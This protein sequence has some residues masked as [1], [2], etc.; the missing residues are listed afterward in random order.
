[1]KLLDYFQLDFNF[2]K[3]WEQ[4]TFKIFLDESKYFYVKNVELDCRYGT[5][6]QTSLFTMTNNIRTFRS[7]S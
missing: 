7:A 2:E 1:M 3:K 5:A 6:E 4:F